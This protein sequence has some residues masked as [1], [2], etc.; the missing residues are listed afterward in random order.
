MVTMTIK[1]VEKMDDRY[2]AAKEAL[3]AE[4]KWWQRVALEVLWGFSRALS[5][6]PRIFKYYMLQ[7]LIAGLF[8]LSRYRRRVMLDNLRRSFPERSKGELRRII[9]RNYSFLAEMVINT[10]N[11]A[12][13]TPKRFGDVIEWQNGVEHREK[14]HGRDWI[15]MATHYGCWE[16]FLLWSWF[17]PEATLSGVYH[18]LR[19]PIFDCFYHRMRHFAPNVHQVPMQNTIRHYVSTRDKCNGIAMGLI[20]DQSPNMRADSHWFEFLN[21][22]TLFHDGAE[23]I[24][25]KFHLP[26][27]FTYITRRAPGRYSLRFDQIYD[28]VEAVEPNQITERY[29]RALERMVS[30]RPELWVWTHRRWR[31]T[32]EKQAKKYGKINR[33]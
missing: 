31:H 19:S 24:A 8:I 2:N 22:P 26:V 23:K 1:K 12:G 18:P 11:L 21:Q 6:S 25:L 13:A 20:S 30:E 15:A 27:Y 5:L 29:V 7:P 4:L 16:Y 32:P 9:R 33:E 14:M 10:L 3:E 17:A 28:G